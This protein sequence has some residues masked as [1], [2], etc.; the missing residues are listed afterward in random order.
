MENLRDQMIPALLLKHEV[1]M[2]R[3]PA[4]PTQQ[5][6]QLP[7]GPVVRDRI[8]DRLDSLE[9]ESSILVGHHDTPLRRLV[10]LRVLN[11]VVPAAVGLPDIDLDTLDRVAS[12]VLYR[13]QCQHGLALWVGCHARAIGERGGVVCVKGPQH[14]TLSGVWRLGVVDVVNEEGETEDIGEEDEFL[15]QMDHQL[16]ELSQ[17]T[18]TI[19][20][21][22]LT[23]RALES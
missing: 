22:S 9:P 13:T 10:A 16:R 19:K 11:V 8:A 3:P 6:Q 4:V 23:I 1:H 21:A 18:S 5:L 14:G 2:C 17:G 20:H 7:D 12:G 15:R